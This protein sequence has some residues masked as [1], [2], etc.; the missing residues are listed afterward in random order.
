M[1]KPYRPKT[2]SSAYLKRTLGKIEEKAKYRA[3]RR[4][5]AKKQ[6]DEFMVWSQESPDEVAEWRKEREEEMFNG[7]RLRQ[8]SDPVAVYEAYRCN[9]ADEKYLADA[10]K[11]RAIIAAMPGDS[12]ELS[13]EIFEI[14]DDYS[15]FARPVKFWQKDEFGAYVTLLVIAATIYY[16]GAVRV[17]WFFIGISIV[18]TAYFFKV[19]LTSRGG[20]VSGLMLLPAIFLFIIGGLMVGVSTVIGLFS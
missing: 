12:T 11:L 15:Y 18:G 4:D 7:G 10:E 6:Y 16:F 14:V 13:D 3:R 2:V 19:L 20:T 5:K 8:D 9:K 17:G 1:R